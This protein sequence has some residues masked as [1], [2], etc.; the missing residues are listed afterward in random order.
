[1]RNLYFALIFCLPF[2]GQ[3]QEH[4]PRCNFDSLYSEQLKSADFREL[5]LH[6]EEVFEK[7]MEQKSKKERGLY[8]IPVVVH[9]VKNESVTD[10]DITD[11]EV[12]RQIEVLN[13]TYNLF[14]EDVIQT[15]ADFEAFIGNPEIEF[16]LA[17][18][19]PNGYATT[20]ITR[21]TTDVSS[22]STA[23][24]NIK[25]TNLGGVD[26]WDT[27]SYLN[28]W[29]GK[30]TTNVLGY[31]HSPNANIPDAEH[32][33]VVGYPFFGDNEHEKYGMGKT[34]VHEIGHYLNL[35]HPWGTGGC[36]SIND[37]VDDTP[38]TE[39]YYDSPEHP[40]ISCESVDMFMN[41]MQYVNDSSMVMFSQGQVDRMHFAL[42]Y[43][44]ASL[45]ES[46]GCGIPSLI[47]EPRV[48]HSSSQSVD[49]GAVFLNI[50]SGVP[51]FIILWEGGE[52]TDSLVDLSTGDYSV[53]ITDSIGQELNLDFTISYYGNVY[54]SDNFESY[55]VDSLL[56]LQSDTW[57]TFCEDSFVANI[58]AI[59]PAEGLQ[60]LEI[61][62][63]DGL[64][65]FR[66]DLGGIDVN[67]YDL[68]F[69]IYVPTVRSAAYT[70][71]HDA[72]CSRPVSAYEI[73]FNN[74]GQGYIKTGG[75]SIPF[76]FPQNQW[77]TVNQ[78]IDMDRDLVA[79]S[80]ADEFVGDWS[81][82]WT[83]GNENGVPK[84]GA[85]VF[86]DKVDSLSQVH[87]FIDDF[88]MEL[89]PNSDI[90]LQEILNGPD[91]VLYPNPTQDQINFRVHD[92]VQEIYEVSLFNTLGQILEMKNWDTK[93]DHDLSVSVDSYK[94]GIYFVRIRS[95]EH[96]QVLKF[97]VNR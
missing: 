51:P 46:N 84:L 87:Y 91:V 8:T 63:A 96:S 54:D 75:Q 17:T 73:Q 90:G 21:H 26:A 32:G 24:D 71:Y 33:V 34:S 79:F 15:P 4:I 92:E 16:C 82:N 78:L 62:A 20:G 48:N 61:N 11:E 60:Y 40:Q 42:S 83:V 52:N 94:Q 45:Q 64:N 59:T 7:Y 14:N 81:F 53:Q 23:L 10:M 29:V 27:D 88:K 1:M 67:A 18:V 55:S 3:A 19:D 9:I 39:P 77:F 47:A 31:S 30:I 38:I 43:F 35:K 86:E 28:I 65:T 85:I 68:S 37:W 56:H 72:S 50:V 25:Y 80:I 66:R 6:E 93:R 49:D 70:I 2:L 74:D 44:R 97:V 89:V 58:A 5:L 12:Y 57:K 22:F 41:Y 69:K 76:N 36:D 13:E 95:K